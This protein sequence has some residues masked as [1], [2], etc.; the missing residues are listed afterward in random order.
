MF[1]SLVAP[2]RTVLKQFKKF[3]LELGVAPSSFKRHLILKITPLTLQQHHEGHKPIST[4]IFYQDFEAS[5]AIQVT[6]HMLL[7]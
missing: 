4:H 3:L 6:S 7:S 5:H 2:M 1:L